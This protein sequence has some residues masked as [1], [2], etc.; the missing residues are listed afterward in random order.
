MGLAEARRSV[1][2]QGAVA[3]LSRRLGD[4]ERGT[5]REAVRIADDE[6]LERVSGRDGQ[7]GGR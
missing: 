7:V 2:E 3:V 6:G 4:S 1:D 5:V